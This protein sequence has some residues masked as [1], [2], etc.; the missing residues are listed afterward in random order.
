LVANAPQERVVEL[1]AP[2]LAAPRTLT[3]CTFCSEEI[4]GSAEKCLYCSAKLSLPLSTA[5]VPR[6]AEHQG[7]FAE[8]TP[9]SFITGFGAPP[10]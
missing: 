7:S 8:D 10:F 2:P 6:A 3:R 4:I 9:E 5:T 1:T